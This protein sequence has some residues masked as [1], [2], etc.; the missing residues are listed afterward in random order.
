[1]DSAFL[2]TLA[3]LLSIALS[4]RA[5]AKEVEVIHQ[6]AIGKNACGP[7]AY[8]NSLL[9]SGNKQALE[10]L[11]GDTSADKVRFFAETFGNVP[12]IYEHKPETAYSDG[13]G[14][15]DQDLLKMVNQSRK[16]SGQSAVSGEHILRKP[17]ESPTAFLERIRASIAKSIASGFHP[18][19]DIR[20]SKP[21]E[22]SDGETRWHKIAGHWVCIV[23]IAHA[24]DDLLVL[25][26]A[27][28]YSGKVVSLALHCDIPNKAVVPVTLSFSEKGK[29]I[30]DWKK[31][32]RCLFV[33]APGLS[34]GRSKTAWFERSYLASTYLISATADE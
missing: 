22:E 2:C 25:E 15:T 31:S 17:G 26:V 8:V 10:S 4:P 34:I 24:A 20:C 30:W 14:V 12:S 16:S 29:V 33:C 6:K 13:D 32:D 9:R 23:A 5:Q 3:A 27:D 21:V 7:C 11:E 1:M 28:S 19:L 18:L